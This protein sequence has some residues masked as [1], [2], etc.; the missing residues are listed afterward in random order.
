[1][2][3]LPRHDAEDPLNFALEPGAGLDALNVGVGGL[4][5]YPGMERH[6]RD[7]GFMQYTQEVNYR[8]FRD[9]LC[10]GQLVYG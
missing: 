10:G 1:M 9:V 4:A 5:A 6:F 7:C 8:H 2:W 3:S